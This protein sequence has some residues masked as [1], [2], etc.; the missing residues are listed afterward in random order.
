MMPYKQLSEADEMNSFFITPRDEEYTPLTKTT[1]T[2]SSRTNSNTGSP[3]DIPPDL[4]RLLQ[5]DPKHG[6]DYQAVLERQKQFGRNEIIEKKRNRF[7]HFLSFCKFDL[8]RLTIA[9]SSYHPSL[10]FIYS[11][12]NYC[13]S[14]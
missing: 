11:Y 1:S 8:A 10:I 3:D 5:T 14:H 4:E 12:G 13:I 7:L 9:P 6:L 2:P